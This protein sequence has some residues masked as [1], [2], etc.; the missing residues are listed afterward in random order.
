MT[1]Q[2]TARRLPAIDAL[3]DH[4]RSIA[5]LEAIL[6][7]D[8]ADRHHS[9]DAHWTPTEAVASMRSGSGDEYTIVF[10]PAG[11]WI[12]GFAHESPMSPY[13]EDGPWPGVLDDVPEAF[14]AYVEEPAFTD[15]DGM[16]VVTACLWR[17]AGD[18]RW[19]TGTID[20]PE[21]PTGD[22]D[23]AESLFALLT[24]RSAEAFQ[25]WA[26]DYYEVPV[27]VEA[28]RHVLA[29]RPLTD[30]VVRALNPALTVA[31]LAMDFAQTGYPQ[32]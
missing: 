15:E 27:D 12:R 22:P 19:S 32:A 1:V 25:Q 10:S 23:G 7:P 18:D 29:S 8:W 13:G 26:E 21:H 30:A 14:R 2:D 31:D 16:P 24:D 4:C 3:R 6:S 11:A 20:F 9:F 17:E 28:V 5:L